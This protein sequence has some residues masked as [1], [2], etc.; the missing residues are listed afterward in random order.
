[1]VSAYGS[2]G[3]VQ[4]AHLRVILLN[5]KTYPDIKNPEKLII[6]LGPTER[7]QLDLGRTKL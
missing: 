4:G 2:N 1:M 6:F 3:L 5:N 7:A